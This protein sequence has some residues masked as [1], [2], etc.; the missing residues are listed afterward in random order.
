MKFELRVALRYLRSRHKSR[1]ISIVTF[2]SVAGVAVGVMALIVVLSVMNGFDRDLRQKIV[3]VNPHIYIQE[4]G[5]IAHPDE[6]IE[7]LKDIKHI[8]G[9]S[10]FIEGQAMLKKDKQASGVLIRGIDS[11]REVGVTNIENYIIKGSLPKGKNDIVIGNQL[12]KAFNLKIGDIITAISPIDRKGFEFKVKG[13]FSSG[14][15]EYDSTLAYI[16]LSSA[17]SFFDTKNLIGAIGIKTDNLF[18]AK[19][20]KK[21]IIKKLG[22]GYW[23][24]TWMGVN[25]NLFSSLKLEKTVMFIILVLIV[26][27]ASFNIISTLIMTVMEKTRDVGILKSLG[28]T[29]RSIALIF[30]YCG[31][32]IGTLGT[33]IGAG[34]G[35]LLCYLLKTYKF[36]K[37]PPDIYYIETLPVQIKWSDSL[38]I[39]L[40]AILISYLATLYPAYQAAKLKPVEAI[41]YE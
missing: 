4:S 36:I 7:K 18:L 6:I 11:K 34:I 30:T 12:A 33:I 21:N 9:A 13:I 17:Q 14:M 3:G 1:F 32:I 39:G 27:V 5:G 8:E 31:L 2:I 22:F 40:A 28:A 41:R 20:I 37:L 38:I 26:L 16:S 15:Y 29:R 10:P 35:F 23:V 24:R 25:K 19:E